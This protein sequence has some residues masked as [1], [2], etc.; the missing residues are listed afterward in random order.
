MLRHTVTFD[1]DVE[2]QTHFARCIEAIE[3]TFL[4]LKGAL[5]GKLGGATEFPLVGTRRKVDG[6]SDQGQDFNLHWM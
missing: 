2:E 3:G 5:C 4:R 1:V 6:L